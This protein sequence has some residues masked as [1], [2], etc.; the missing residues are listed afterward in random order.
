MQVPHQPRQHRIDGDR[1]DAV[2]KALR[3]GMVVKRHVGRGEATAQPDERAKEL[4]EELMGSDDNLHAGT[5]VDRTDGERRVAVRP[6]AGPAAAGA[7]TFS[8][9]H[10]GV[11]PEL[12]GAF[13]ARCLL[14]FQ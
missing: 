5:F 11:A 2:G 12:D 1:F 10:R 8:A 9:G 4:M 7:P 6:V 13:H 14:C 3:I